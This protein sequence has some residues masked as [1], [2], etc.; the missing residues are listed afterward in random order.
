MDTKH[1]EFL[2]G[3]SHNVLAIEISK[4]GK[5][6]ASGQRN[7]MGFRSHLIVWDWKTRLEIVR[8]DLHKVEVVSLCFSVEEDFIMSLGGKDCGTIVIWNLKKK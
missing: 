4:S 2:S 3:H 7:H 8:H 6:L 5:V 1:Q